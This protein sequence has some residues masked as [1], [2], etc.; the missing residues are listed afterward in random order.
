MPSSPTRSSAASWL[1]VSV[2]GLALWGI[3]TDFFPISQNIRPSW[4]VY[5]WPICFGTC[6]RNRFCLNT[7]SGTAAITDLLVSIMMLIATYVTVRHVRTMGSRTLRHRFAIVTGCAV[8]FFVMSDGLQSTLSAIGFPPPRPG[9]SEVAGNSRPLRRLLS[10]LILPGI[11]L[12]LFACGYS[13]SLAMADV[14]GRAYAK[15]IE[16]RG[17]D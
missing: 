10:P 11:G 14:C 15:A 13:F 12:G 1:A 3:Q 6:A 9:I 7:F 5:G 17:A 8:L 16:A 2:V 4:Y